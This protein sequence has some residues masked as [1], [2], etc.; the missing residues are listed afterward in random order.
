[1]TFDEIKDKLSAFSVGI[2]GCGGLGSNCAVALARLGIGRLVIADFD[3]I[4][5]SNL[6]RQYFFYDQIGLKKAAALKTNL[7]RIAPDCKVWAHEIRITPEDI[8]RLF[9]SCDVIVEAFDAADQKKMLMEQVSCIYPEKLL[10]C[11]SG[12]AGSDFLESLEIKKFGN[13]VVC[14]DHRTQV[15]EECPPLAPKVAIVANMQ[16]NIVLNHLLNLML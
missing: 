5:E 3:T 6:N 15:S 16:A 8:P 14:G 1:M 12:L 2:A 13:L 11:V 4:V 10:V 9:H 7:G